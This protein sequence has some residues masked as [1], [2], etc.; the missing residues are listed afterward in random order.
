[1]ALDTYTNLKTA[2]ANFLARDDL[3]SEI[4]DFIES[5]FPE[6]FFNSD[7]ESFN[8]GRLEVRDESLDDIWDELGMRIQTDERYASFKEYLKEYMVNQV[9]LNDN[10]P[11]L[12]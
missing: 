4:D 2:I 6:D 3:T 8:R 7:A 5:I 11:D 10:M 1:M 9:T 12:K